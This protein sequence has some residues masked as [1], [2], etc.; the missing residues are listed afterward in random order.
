MEVGS[1]LT[2]RHQS[3]GLLTVE[4]PVPLRVCLARPTVRRRKKKR[5]RSK[6][7]RRKGENTATGETGV[8]KH[9]VVPE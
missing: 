9:C 4:T 2:G 1:A 8:M 7:K 5:R 6:K 3:R